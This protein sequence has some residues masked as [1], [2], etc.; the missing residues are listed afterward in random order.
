MVD[1]DGILSFCGL[2]ALVVRSWLDSG[3]VFVRNACAGSTAAGSAAAGSTD[4]GRVRADVRRRLLASMPR[5]HKIRSGI[6]LDNRG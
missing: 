3:E 4:R 6:E 2:Q 5:G 1:A